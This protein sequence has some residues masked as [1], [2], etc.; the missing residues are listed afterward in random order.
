MNF[1]NHIAELYSYILEI[2]LSLSSTPVLLFDFADMLVL[3]T[4]GRSRSHRYK[5]LKV[6]STVLLGGL[7][8]SIRYTTRTRGMERH[9]S[10]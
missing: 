8:T 6:K 4:K 10:S 2:Y 9:S 1:G 5:I 7:M 3:W